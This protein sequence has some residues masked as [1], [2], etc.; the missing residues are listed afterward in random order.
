MILLVA[1]CLRLIGCAKQH[2]RVSGAH[3][4]L[5]L[6][7]LI[8]AAPLGLKCGTYKSLD[9]DEMRMLSESEV[10]EKRFLFVV[11]LVVCDSS[12]SVRGGGGAE[13]LRS[14]NLTHIFPFSERKGYTAVKNCLKF[15]SLSKSI[16]NELFHFKVFRNFD[17]TLL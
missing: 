8:S 10:Y 5:F 7:K 3:L 16:R 2:Y 1:L 6:K 12:P 14:K 11:Q 15:V 17:Q 13:K 9:L 4:Y